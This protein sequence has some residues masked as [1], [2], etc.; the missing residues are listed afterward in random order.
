LKKKVATKVRKKSTPKKKA[1]ARKATPR[2]KVSQ[3]E[4]APAMNTSESVSET[5]TSASELSQEPTTIEFSETTITSEGELASADDS[6]SI[7]STM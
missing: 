4:S 3:M 2:V 6:T 5:T 7:S 1:A